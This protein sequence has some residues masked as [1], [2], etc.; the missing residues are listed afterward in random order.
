MRHLYINSGG[1]MEELLQQLVELENQCARAFNRRDIDEILKHFAADIS[2]FSSTKHE[3]FSGKNELRETFEYYLSEAEDVS[4]EI[5]NPAVMKIQDTAIMSFYWMVTLK[6]GTTKKEIPG[7]GTHAYK[8]Q[9]DTWQ[10]VHE[11]FSRAH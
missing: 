8:K 10:I 3:R 5:M 9:G 2:G 11:H 4:F 6:S 7:R 1:K